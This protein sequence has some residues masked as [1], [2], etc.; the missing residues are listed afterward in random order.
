MKPKP[1]GTYHP[2]PCVLD[3]DC[4]VPVELFDV[5]KSSREIWDEYANNA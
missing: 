1:C 4:A 2:L 5:D 3:E